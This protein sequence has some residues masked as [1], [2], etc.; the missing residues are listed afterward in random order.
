MQYRLCSTGHRVLLR[1]GVPDGY[2]SSRAG[3]SIRLCEYRASRRQL[4]ACGYVST[5]HRVGRYLWTGDVDNGGR[6]QTSRLV[7]A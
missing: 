3:T 5:R 7:A 6:S 4:P 2:V 1:E